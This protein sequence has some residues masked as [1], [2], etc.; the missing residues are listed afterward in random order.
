MKKGEENEP[1]K[2]KNV[3]YKKL[4]KQIKENKPNSNNIIKVSTL[5]TGDLRSKHDKI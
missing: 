3:S 1:E 2:K 4:L 5:A